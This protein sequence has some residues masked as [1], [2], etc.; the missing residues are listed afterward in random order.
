MFNHYS[1]PR[2]R[3][4]FIFILSLLPPRAPREGWS[5][6][7]PLTPGEEKGGD[8]R[9]EYGKETGGASGF[10]KRYCS[11]IMILLQNKTSDRVA[12]RPAYN[13]VG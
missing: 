8:K 3:S 11:N 5:P 2:Y 12:R 10:I 7:T 1:T 13:P 9:D 6:R 4:I